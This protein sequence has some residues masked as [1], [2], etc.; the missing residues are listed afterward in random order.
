MSENNLAEEFKKG[1]MHFLDKINF[2]KSFLDAEAIRFMNEVPGKVH[3]QLAAAPDLLVALKDLQ[4]AVREHGLLNV[5]KR[6]SLCAADAQ[7]NT[8][9]AK[10]TQ[11]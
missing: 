10:A 3:K 8:A 4:E 2:D 7:A 9:I 1:W 11:S 6:F 5:K